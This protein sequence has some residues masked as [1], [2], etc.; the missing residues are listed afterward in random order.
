KATLAAE[1]NGIASSVLAGFPL[2][3]DKLDYAAVDSITL[4]QVKAAAKKQLS[5]SNYVLVLVGDS[6]SI[7]KQWD[8]VP[9]QKPTVK[10]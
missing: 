3:Q 10:K 1:M 8:G 6:Q 5:L 9:F 4:E 7:L 2:G